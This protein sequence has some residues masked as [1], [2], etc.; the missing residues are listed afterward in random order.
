MSVKT[1]C[2]YQSIVCQITYNAPAA[3]IFKYDACIRNGP[4]SMPSDEAIA[5]KDG[6]FDHSILHDNS[7][8]QMILQTDSKA[9]ADRLA[10]PRDGEYYF[11]SL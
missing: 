3:F 11:I 9:Y 2:L 1:E 4:A 6:W 10:S 5:D 8:L 7:P